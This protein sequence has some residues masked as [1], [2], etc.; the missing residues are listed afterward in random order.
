[1]AGYIT[2]LGNGSSGIKARPQRWLVK[3]SDG[4]KDT[5]TSH[6]CG[7]GLQDPR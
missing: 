4:M 7:H 6:R 1:M 3:I 2:I 5:V